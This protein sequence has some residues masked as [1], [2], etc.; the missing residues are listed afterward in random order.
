[1][2]QTCDGPRVLIVEDEALIGL[3]IAEGLKEVGYR[4]VG[5]AASQK[6]ALTLVEQARPHVAVLDLAL[7]DGFCIG[8]ARELSASNIPFMIL[9]AFPESRSSRTCSVPH[10]GSLSRVGSRRSP[11]HWGSWLAH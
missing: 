6:E 11:V 4:I 7:R 3:T 8:L 5:P 1:M 2:Q 10:L 9:R